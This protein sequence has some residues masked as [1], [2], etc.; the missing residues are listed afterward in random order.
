MND[1]GELEA[2]TNSE[3]AELGMSEMS[4]WFLRLSL[5]I[6]CLP[7]EMSTLSD[8][9]LFNVFVVD[10]EGCYWSK[11][12]QGI[13]NGRS[14]QEGLQFLRYEAVLSVASQLPGFFRGGGELPPS[15]FG[16]AENSILHVNQ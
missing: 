9:L 3:W 7:Y 2:L 16:Y 11:V 13:L 1:E 8:V 5:S 6:S 14:V 15:P 12:Q 4:Q 10:R